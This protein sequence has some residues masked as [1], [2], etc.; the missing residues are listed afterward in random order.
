MY[1]GWPPITLIVTDPEFSPKQATFVI[2]GSVN[3]GDVY[4]FTVAGNS[5]TYTAVS[6]DGYTEVL[7][8]SN[9]CDSSI[10]LNLTVMPPS[11]G[12]NI[13]GLDTIS[14]H[15]LVPV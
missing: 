6:N 14:F 10:S 1:G 3:T 8:A 2:S 11:S 5:D 7:T 15:Y 4:T 12:L 9:N 13:I